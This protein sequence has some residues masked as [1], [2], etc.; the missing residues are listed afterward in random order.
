[1]S[2]IRVECAGCATTA[3]LATGALL[4]ALAA[5][6]DPA[7]FAAAD[8]SDPRPEHPEQPTGGTRFTPDDL[9]T[10][11]E[12]LGTDAWFLTAGCGQP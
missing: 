7:N 1:M 11:H 3:D 4:L 8:Y 2:T 5:P 6:R 12:Q 10:L 9:L